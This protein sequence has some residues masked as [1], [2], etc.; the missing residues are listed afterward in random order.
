MMT[1]ALSRRVVFGFVTCFCLPIVASAQTPTE[2]QLAAQ[3]AQ[4]PQNVG[5]LLDLAKFYADRQLLQQAQTTL[6][7]AMAILNEQ[8]RVQGFSGATSTTGAVRIGG[9]I[10]Q[11][12]Q[13]KRVEPQYPEDAKAAG[14]TGMVILEVLLD[15]EGRVKQAAILRHA[16][17]SI[18]QAALNAVQ[19]WVY[20][21]T[22]LNGNPV[23]VVFT[24]TVN[25]IL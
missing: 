23:E 9:D 14:T 16:T 19:Q 6:Q 15:T 10:K 1:S 25:F 21:P 24:V 5:P 12:K 7:R 13:I 22:L 18:D 11:P 20:T 3:V 2:A 8:I 4:Q 17:P